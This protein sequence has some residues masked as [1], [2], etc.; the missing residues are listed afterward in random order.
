MVS[1]NTGSDLIRYDLRMD[2]FIDAYNFSAELV[3]SFKLPYLL[4]KLNEC[5][6]IDIDKEWFDGTVFE[7][8]GRHV[9]F[10]GTR[11][12]GDSQ[13]ISPRYSTI[14]MGA[15]GNI[16]LYTSLVVAFEVLPDEL[17]KIKKLNEN[18]DLLIGQLKGLLQCAMEIISYRYNEKSAGKSNMSLSFADCDRIHGAFF[19]NYVNKRLMYWD[20]QTLTPTTPNCGSID[21]SPIDSSDMETAP[22]TWRYFKNKSIYSY[23]SGEYV[24]SIIAAAVCI[25]SLMLGIVKEYCKKNNIEEK[26]YTFEE[27]TDPDGKIVSKALSLTKLA[28]KLVADGL[29]KTSLSNTQLT[30][31]ISKILVPRNDIMHGKVPIAQPWKSTASKV[32]EALNTIISSLDIQ[33]QKAQSAIEIIPDYRKFLKE[34]TNESLS[35]DERLNLVEK[36]SLQYPQYEYLKVL[37]A[38]LLL[39][40]KKEK[41]AKEQIV[42]L[43]RHTKNKQAIIID[44]FRVLFAL[45][46]YDDCFSFLQHFSEDEKDVRIWVGE[47]ILNL[48]KYRDCEEV[49]YLN[50]ALTAI[51][52]SKISGIP[53]LLR[54]EIARQIY[55]EKGN[56]SEAIRY[57]DH[58][59]FSVPYFCEPILF[60]CECHLALGNFETAYNT[61][62]DFVTKYK[63]SNPYRFQ[64]D[65]IFI[66]YLPDQIIHRAIELATELVKNIDDNKKKLLIEN[67]KSL[68]EKKEDS[69]QIIAI[70]F[71]GPIAFM[72]S[73]HFP[74][75]LIKF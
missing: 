3:L 71:C 39:S 26:S 16:V 61:L 27:L 32:N 54:S 42:F 63:D 68:T 34:L 53:Y 31:N 1:L 12:W 69:H 51:E 67:L 11:N 5:Y 72:E 55:R 30:N 38:Q 7:G 37:K 60:S 41:E 47:A 66:Q 75:H 18:N 20:I 29:L 64:M 74:S 19:E 43:L 14:A 21:E 9:I 33:I 52:N 65:Y 13:K 49:K 35:L 25:E 36:A 24:D 6:I 23:S 57:S 59:K 8:N 73:P 48:A 62:M 70:P 58:L 45:K 40:L 10:A 28:K 17:L 44:V 56:Y 4:P 22:Q 50:M 15:T 46:R 2:S